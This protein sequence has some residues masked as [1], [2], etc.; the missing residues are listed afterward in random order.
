MATAF[1][2]SDW[3]HKNY[4]VRDFGHYFVQSWEEVMIEFPLRAVCEQW[5]GT[6]LHKLLFV[7]C[8]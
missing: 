4:F 6:D 5:F 2:F 1:L 3:G 8:F 7:T